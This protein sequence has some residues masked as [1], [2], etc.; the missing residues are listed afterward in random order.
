VQVLEPK[1]HNSGI[2][3]GQIIRRHKI[4]LPKPCEN[5]YFTLEHFNVGCDVNLYGKTFYVCGCD[6]FTR[7]FLNRLG[8]PVAQNME[9]PND[10]GSEKLKDVI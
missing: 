7:S 9:L 10:P 2:P 8:I 4:P 6:G 5:Q 1:T 3:Q